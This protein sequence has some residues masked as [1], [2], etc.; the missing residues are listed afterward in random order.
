MA[1]PIQG[2][3]PFTGKAAKW[4]LDYLE[5]HTK[6]NPEQARKDAEIAARIKPLPREEK[7]E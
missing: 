3:A 7:R 1:R 6:R 5:N 2:I 4:L